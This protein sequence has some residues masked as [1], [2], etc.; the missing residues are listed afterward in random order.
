[1]H[2]LIKEQ[3][4]NVGPIIRALV[5]DPYFVS[6]GRVNSMA[7]LTDEE[8]RLPLQKKKRTKKPHCSDKNKQL[9]CL[10]VNKQGQAKWFHLTF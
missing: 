2:F 5:L 10:S 8:Q 9:I 7:S 6:I 4:Q 3:E 1:M